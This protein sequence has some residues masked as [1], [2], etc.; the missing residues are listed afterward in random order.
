MENGDSDVSNPENWKAEAVV[1]KWGS[2]MGARNGARP[3]GRIKWHGQDKD[4][5]LA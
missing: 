1:Q 3:A 5:C 2:R 4:Q